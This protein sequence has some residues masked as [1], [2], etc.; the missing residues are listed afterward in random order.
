M[1]GRARTLAG[2]ARLPSFVLCALGR[3][4]LASTHVVQ[5]EASA[6]KERCTT[7]A[8]SF[9]HPQAPPCAVPR[10]AR[11]SCC[12]VCAPTSMRPPLLSSLPTRRQL[13]VARPPCLPA[14]EARNAAQR[15]QKNLSVEQ[16][17]AASCA[18]VHSHGPP[19]IAPT[20]RR[21]GQAEAWGARQKGGAATC[22][23]PRHHRGRR[24][25][26]FMQCA[27]AVSAR[28][29]RL[30]TA[31]KERE[32]NNNVVTD[33]CDAPRC[34]ARTRLGARGGARGRPAPSVL[35]LAR[36]G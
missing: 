21:R 13:T 36:H 9:P 28:A 8:A 7:G 35:R 17:S 15:P 4:P 3:P 19:P 32:K 20:R 29:R 5:Q 18:F 12:C 10:L 22:R 6:R 27:G 25:Q 23:L 34:R 1:Y 16:K 2:S 33:Q 30:V 11:A 31:K 24:G 14:C 26:R